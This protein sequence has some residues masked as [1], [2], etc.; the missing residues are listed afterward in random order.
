MNSHNPAFWDDWGVPAPDWPELTAKERCV[1]AH[2]AEEADL[3]EIVL[4]FTG[5]YV[6]TPSGGA[7][8]SSVDTQSITPLIRSA[9]R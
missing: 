1:I 4:Y 8:V 2:A 6:E 3:R 9:A 7:W 5:H